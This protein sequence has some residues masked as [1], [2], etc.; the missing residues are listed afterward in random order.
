MQSFQ[1]NSFLQKRFYAIGSSHR[2]PASVGVNITI[3]ACKSWV[4]NIRIISMSGRHNKKFHAVNM[5]QMIKVRCRPQIITFL[6]L[7]IC[8]IENFTNFYISLSLSLL[9]RARQCCPKVLLQYWCKRHFYRYK[10]LQPL[11]HW[12]KRAPRDFEIFYH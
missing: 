8:F 2:L 4:E 7:K 10:E 5:H 6:G 12:L 3:N 1:V 9:L 11:A